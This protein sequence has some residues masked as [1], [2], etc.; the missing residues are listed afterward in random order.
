M[1]PRKS[2]LKTLLKFWLTGNRYECP[3][4]GSTFRAF[5]PY[6]LDNRPNAACPECGSKERDR[7]LWLYLKNK[8]DLFTGRLKL[9][10]VAPEKVIQ[11]KIKDLPNLDYL[12]ADLD[13]PLAMEKMDLT[14]IRYAENYFDAIICNHVL[15]HIPDDKT[16][17]RELYRVLRPGGW[18]ILQVPINLDLETTYEDWNI[19]DQYE[20][21][22]AFGQK[23]H[24]RVY[25]Q[26]YVKRLEDAG[27]RA[28][29]DWYVRER[30]QKWASGYSLHWNEPIF[31]C[32]K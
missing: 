4:C 29:T 26:D 15:E 8:T 5:L 22:E 28:T 19:T 32:E 9:L 23:D 10:H 18:A 14:E 21:E 3:L 27:F 7:L 6:G 2:I 1:V 20:R 11:D 12:S 17:M 16:A 30:G 24:V 25:G 13:S 31:Y